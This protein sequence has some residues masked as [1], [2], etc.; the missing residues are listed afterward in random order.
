VYPREDPQATIFLPKIGPQPAMVPAGTP[1]AFPRPRRG[2]NLP[3]SR[4][5]DARGREAVFLD[6]V[7]LYTNLKV[8]CTWV[9]RGAE[10]AVATPG[11]DERRVLA[12]SIHGR[13]GRAFLTEGL[14]KEGRCAARLCRY[15]DDLRRSDGSTA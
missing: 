13:T 2:R 8:G 12:G 10:A 1:V 14:P 11:T 9:R 3:A 4:T 6:E 7:E 15:R 5:T